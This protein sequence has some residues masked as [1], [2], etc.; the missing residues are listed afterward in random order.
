MPTLLRKGPY[1]FHFYSH[2]SHE[3]PHVHVERDDCSAKW[4][5]VPVAIARNDGFSA[6][7]LNRLH[8]V[9]REHAVEFLEAWDD[10]F[11]G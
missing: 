6:F 8:A 3:P 10:F 4:W 11:G 2:D 7:E 9:V 5:L 1:R